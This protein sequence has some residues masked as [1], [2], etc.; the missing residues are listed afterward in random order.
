MNETLSLD[1]NKTP[2]GKNKDE[3]SKFGKILNALKTYFSKP[4]NIILVILQYY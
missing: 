4:S 2:E 1:E 3:L